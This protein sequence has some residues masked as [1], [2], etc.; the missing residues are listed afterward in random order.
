M[1][2]WGKLV[3]WKDQ[4]SLPGSIIF[5]L[6]DFWLIP[7]ESAW[8]I[9]V[10]CFKRMWRQKISS[11][12]QSCW[13]IRWD[14]SGGNIQHSVLSVYM[15][16]LLVP[17]G[18]TLVL[19]PPIPQWPWLAL[20]PKGWEHTFSSSFLLTALLTIW[21]HCYTPDFF[22]GI[23]PPRWQTGPDFCWLLAVHLL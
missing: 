22:Q 2:K 1:K 12:L 4:N 6:C 16:F 18:S 3:L 15:L 7:K 19:T 14:K 23:L 10:P 11:S 8:Q 20:N 5:W 21:P 9:V 13:E 17:A